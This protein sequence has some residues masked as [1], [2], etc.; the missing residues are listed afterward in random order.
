MAQKTA[1]KRPAQSTFSDEEKAAM[2]ELVRERR[3]ASSGKADGEADA[4]AKIA[5][6]QDSDRKIAERIHA[7]VKATAP[8]LAPKAWYGM[9][10]YARDDK[11][12]LFFQSAHKFKSRY[13]TLGFQDAAHLD[14]D[15]FWPVAFALTKLTPAVEAKIAELVKRAAR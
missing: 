5:E 3:R 11:V 15:E 8:N 12:V 9:P 4:L 2:K 13:S 1:K 14:D 7:I 10:A 6:M